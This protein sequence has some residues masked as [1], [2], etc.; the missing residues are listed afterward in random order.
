MKCTTFFKNCTE[1]GSE[2][3]STD[4]HKLCLFCFGEEHHYD[5]CVLCTCFTKHW[6]NH[7]TW[8]CT[9]LLESAL[10]LPIASCRL[11]LPPP[12]LWRDS[13]G[14]SASDLTSSKKSR[15]TDDLDDHWSL[16]CNSICRFVHLS[17][18]E[19]PTFGSFNSCCGSSL[20]EPLW[21]LESQA[22]PSSRMSSYLPPAQGPIRFTS[23]LCHSL[24]WL[25][26][27]PQLSIAAHWVL[28]FLGYEDVTQ[29]SHW[30]SQDRPP[31]WGSS[32]WSWPPSPY[33][34]LGTLSLLRIWIR[35]LIQHPLPQLGS[36][37]SSKP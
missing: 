11:T 18:A 20:E 37:V 10:R 26:L 15:K 21:S 9:Q 35:V 28:S 5:T 30:W 19:I 8:L 13:F 17:S 25:E 14:L 24:G 27:G 12:K 34:A 32:H 7:T 36:D 1:C 33:Y 23:A 6:K 31:S 29:V 3:P 16:W 22:T 4:S 2:L